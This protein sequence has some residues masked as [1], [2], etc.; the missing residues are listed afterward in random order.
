MDCLNHPH[1]LDSARFMALGFTL[2]QEPLPITAVL[3]T[4]PTAARRHQRRV[5][6]GRPVAAVTTPVTP[7]I[8]PERAAGSLRVGSLQ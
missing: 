5:H 1:M 3:P 2:H 4:I 8:A 7:P 6:R